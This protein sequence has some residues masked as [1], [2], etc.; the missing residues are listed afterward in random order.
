MSNC[1]CRSI[2]VRLSYIGTI[3]GTSLAREKMRKDINMGSDG[4]GDLLARGGSDSAE[5]SAYNRTSVGK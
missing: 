3:A 4:L 1:K 5:A 2:K